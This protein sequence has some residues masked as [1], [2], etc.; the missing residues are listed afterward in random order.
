MVN[1]VW[2]ELFL[3]S[4]SLLF[5]ILRRQTREVSVKAGELKIQPE[6][7]EFV[8]MTRPKGPK[9]RCLMKKRN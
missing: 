9:Y 8:V 5:L 4:A 7:L 1:I 3:A 2:R 6:L